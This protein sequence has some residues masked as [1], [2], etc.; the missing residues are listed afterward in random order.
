MD[1]FVAI[2]DPTRRSIV[3][4]LANGECSFGE[5]ADKYEMSRPAVSQHLKVLR[6]AGIVNV[7]PDAQRRI[8]SLSDDALLIGCVG[9]LV[10]IKDVPTLVRAFAAL[11]AELGAHLAIVGD[12]DEMRDRRSML[13]GAMKKFA[14]TKVRRELERM[15]RAGAG[16]ERGGGLDTRLKAG[17]VLHELQIPHHQVAELVAVGL[18]SSRCEHFEL[19]ELHYL[20]LVMLEREDAPVDTGVSAHNDPV[21]AADAKNAVHTLL[22]KKFNQLIN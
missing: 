15:I 18:L 13:R 3:L 4:S 5:L 11:P 7:R 10:P 19:V 20:V 8:Y 9:R 22:T 17:S 12:G 6:D 14:G 21:L 1:T 2:A 16:D